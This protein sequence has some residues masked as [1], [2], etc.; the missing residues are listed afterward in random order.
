MMRGTLSNLKAASVLD[1]TPILCLLVLLWLVSSGDVAH[2]FGM[3]A[4]RLV[5]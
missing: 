4:K 3:G 5:S 1:I 2:F